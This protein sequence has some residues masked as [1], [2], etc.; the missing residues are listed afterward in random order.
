MNI[1][2]LSTIYHTS[3]ILKSPETNFCDPIDDEL[4]WTL[5]PTGP[6][7]ME[8]FKS[9]DIDLGYIGLP[10][11]M[12]GVDKGLKLKCVAGG[13][14]EGTVMISKDSFS[15][16]DDLNNVDDV[17]KQFEGKNIGTPAQGSIH[18]VIIRDLIQD[19]GISIIN[20]PWADFIPQAMQSDEIAAGLGTPA[21]ATVASREIDSKIIIPS[22]KLWPYN[23]SYGIVVREELINQGPDFIKHFLTAHEA[24]CNFLRNQPHDAADVAAGELGGID[25]DFVLETFQISPRYCASLPEEYI[26]STMDFVPVLQK[27]GYLEKEIKKEDIFDLKFIQEVHPEPSHY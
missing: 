13:H 26:R 16:L 20:Y 22:S 15:S 10:P 23:P 19:M 18:D 12:I 1:G 9:G 11:V 25:R 24:A 6:A 2:Y 27:L 17:L 3:F 8:A 7:M 4:N 5:F 21:L 14:V